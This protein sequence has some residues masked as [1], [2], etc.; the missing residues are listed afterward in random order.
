MC[1]FAAR[2]S[3]GW[4]TAICVGC[5][6]EAITKN[7]TV[8]KTALEAYSRPRKSGIRAILPLRALAAPGRPSRATLGRGELTHSSAEA[9]C[10][11]SVGAPRTKSAWLSSSEA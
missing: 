8:K 2:A 1:H 11:R 10:P 7:G 4:R 9:Q 3:T 6:R 5:S